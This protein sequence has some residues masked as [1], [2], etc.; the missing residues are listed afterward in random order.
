MG[1]NSFQTSGSSPG[2]SSRCR[3]AIHGLGPV[4]GA[5]A[6][7]V[8]THSALRLVA[9]CDRRARELRPRFPAQF[10]PL[11]WTDRYDDLLTGDADIIVD[12]RPAGEPTAD[13]VRAALLSGKSVV[14]ANRHL[15][16]SSGPAL[17]TLAERQGRQLRYAAAVG[18]AMPLVPVLAEALSG[19]HIVRVD[20]TLSGMANA[21]L[22][23]MTTRA[24]ALDDA[25]A[26]ACAMGIAE[27]DPLADLSGATSVAA[28]RVV[29]ALAFGLD[30]RRDDV[31]CASATTVTPASLR[32]ASARG[33]VVRLV[34][35]ASYDSEAD[36]LEAWVAPRAL[37]A[38]DPLAAT[39]GATVVAAI[40]GAAT[41]TISLSGPGAGADA[42][43]TAVV[44][45]LL[46]IARDRAAIVPAPVLVRPGV[47][48]PAP[49]STLSEAL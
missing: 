47:V 19:D 29:C 48:M 46:T 32:A 43:A 15:M 18:G 25:I 34:S 2:D 1:L 38:H 21:V 26:E 42:V 30:V 12:A 20:A 36:A 17:L 41:G 39:D 35:H 31:A 7:R 40:R 11:T 23:T 44:S 16:A 27:G 24:C 13:A 22:A 33:E 14:T 49:N 37:S 8:S 5:V 3:V 45:D 28:L 10:D 9:F 4:G 6:R